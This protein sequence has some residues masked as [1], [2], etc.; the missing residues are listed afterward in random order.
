MTDSTFSLQPRNP[1]GTPPI[2]AGSVNASTTN[3]PPPTDAGPAGLGDPLS[4]AGSRTRCVQGLPGPIAPRERDRP[5]PTAPGDAGRGE[6]PGSARPDQ[7][8]SRPARHHRHQNPHR[9]T[10]EFTGTFI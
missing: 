3:P 2:P 5:A 1:P 9:L 6:D 7:R 8:S 10:P 4:P